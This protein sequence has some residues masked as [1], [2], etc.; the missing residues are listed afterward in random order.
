MA[1]D[2]NLS[3]NP[4]KISGICSRLMCCLKYENH[5]YVDEKAGRQNNGKREK[6]PRIGGLVLTPLG[7]GVLVGLNK[8]ERTANVKLAENNTVTV[9]WDELADAA[10]AE[11]L[12]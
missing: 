11:T 8:K 6:I 3:L 12:V 1:K 9:N 2:Q 4:A 7:E 5:R 10:E